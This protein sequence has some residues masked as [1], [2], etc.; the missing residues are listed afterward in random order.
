MKP[1]QGIAAILVI[2]G[3][4]AVGVIAQRSAE[5]LLVLNQLADASFDE[6]RRHHA[7][8]Q[9]LLN[10]AW[11]RKCD[12][13][14][15]KLPPLTARPAPAHSRL[16]A[17]VRLDRAR[18]LVNEQ[19]GRWTTL[20][21]TVGPCIDGWERRPTGRA[22]QPWLPGL[23][24]HRRPIGDDPALSFSER[25]A[26]V[27]LLQGFVRSV[28]DLSSIVCT[29]ADATAAAFRAA[30]QERSL[31]SLY[32]ALLYE[33]RRPGEED[34]AGPFG[35]AATRLEGL[36]LKPARGVDDPRLNGPAVA[37]RV[38]RWLA[39][40]EMHWAK[41]GRP[42]GEAILLT[43]LAWRVGIRQVDAWL[44]AAAVRMGTRSAAVTF[45]DI[46]DTAL[47][48]AEADPVQLGMFD[49]VPRVVAV[50]VVAD[51]LCPVATE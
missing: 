39:A 23:P 31:A 9:N 4:M 30:L 44:G 20:M 49:W 46:E 8:S 2:V 47:A 13:P 19:V 10:E 15:R 14:T 29:D 37:P 1:W 18:A 43:L 50:A 12:Q 40:T 41:G 34:F 45:V 5:S 16:E 21:A 35:I 6:A 36:G 51:D 22:V 42:R 48:A 3:M 25:V 32:Q 27:E 11:T 26:A 28:Q 24:E 33:P 38:A 17:E 7:R